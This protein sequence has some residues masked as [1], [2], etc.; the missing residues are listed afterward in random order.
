M[1]RLGFMLAFVLAAAALSLPA[2]ASPVP[3]VSSSTLEEPASADCFE[4]HYRCA[5]GGIPAA[6]GEPSFA[7]AIPSARFP[8]PRAPLQIGDAG[9]APHSAASLPIL[10]RNFRK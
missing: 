7:G 9:A 6:H 10:F 3:S 5:P 8:V 4:A 2:G 1:M